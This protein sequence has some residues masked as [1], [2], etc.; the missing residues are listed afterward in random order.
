MLPGALEFESHAFAGREVLWFVDNTVALGGIIK[1]ASREPVL[2]K[3]VAWFWTLS[4]QLRCHIW[5]EYFDT[6]SSRSDGISRVFG[7][8]PCARDEHFANSQGQI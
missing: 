2:E 3:L 6:D 4:Y 7:D 8:D 5:G 1:G